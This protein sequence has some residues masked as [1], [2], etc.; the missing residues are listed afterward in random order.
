MDTILPSPATGCPASA[1]RL[2]PR[3]ALKT[4]IGFW[5]FYFVLNT[6]RMA[7]SF[8]LPD[9]VDMMKRRLVVVLIGILLTYVLY[10]ILRRLE[11]EPLRVMVTAAFLTAIPI[12]IA[13]ATIN[14]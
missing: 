1:C 6:V 14:Y 3:V 11:G 8:G 5:V 12:C 9:Q 7:I 10:S 13:Y 4:I 2:D